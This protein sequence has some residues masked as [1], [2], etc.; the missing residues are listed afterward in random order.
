MSSRWSDRHEEAAG[1]R[2]GGMRY[3]LGLRLALWHGV[4]FIVSATVLVALTYLLLARSLAAQDRQVI[5]SMLTRYVSAYD[6][7]GLGALEG[8]IA[9]DRGAGRHERLLVRVVGQRA[10]ALYVNIPAGWNEFDLSELNVGRDARSW[11]LS[12]P[13]RVDRTTLEVA[14]LRLLDGTVVQVGRSSDVRDELL[15]QF[16]SRVLLVLGL[17]VGIAVLGSGFLTYVGLAP[18]RAMA[19]AVRSIVQTGRL[20][21][22]VTTRGT[23]DALDDVGVL[24]NGMLDRIQALVNAMRGALDNVAH[25]LRTPLARVRSVAE[26]ALASDDPAAARDALARVLEETERV[27]TMLTTLMDISEAE[28]G[29]MRLART[30]I[31]VASVVGE[32]IDL[33]SDLAE[34]QGVVLRATVDP[35]IAVVADP[36]RLRQVI[37]NLVDNAIK[38]TD[39]GGEVVVDAQDA[40]SGVTVRVRDTGHGIAPDDLPRIWD[41][42]YRADASRSKRGLGLGLSLV[43]AIVESHGGRVA[44]ESTPGRGSTFSIT[45]PRTAIEA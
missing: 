45:L 42:L 43:K 14:T 7:G 31:S 20:D 37:A 33:Y 40:A 44:V 10:E 13:G 26:S 19:A 24:V 12:I 2:P 8:A 21:A 1:S 35:A 11:W 4:L 17:I 6:S 38:Y 36:T 28:T 9:A 29:A 39:A 30:R 15:A 41:R 32:A 3:A 34:E 27:N 25:D 5:Q 23:G 22:R 16:R 18:V